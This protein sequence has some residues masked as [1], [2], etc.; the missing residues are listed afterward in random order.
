VNRVRIIPT[1][2]LDDIGLYKTIN[3][4]NPTYIGDPINTVQI[5]NTKEVDELIIID[6][7]ARQN[8]RDINYNYIEE[9]VSEAF[10]PICYGGNINNINQC[11]KLFKL[12]V[13]KISLNY[14]AIFNPK[15]ITELAE[16]FGSQSI[17]VS[18][19][20]KKNFFGK[21]KIYT[22]RGT[23]SIEIDIVT[24]S[25]Q[26]ENYGAGEI[27]LT[28]IDSEGKS[29][30]FDLETIKIVSDSVKIPVIANG[31]CR[32]INDIFLAISEGNASAVAASSMFVYWGKLKGVLINYPSQDILINELFSKFKK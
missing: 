10:M 30:G 32:N 22:E 7:T 21:K 28:S 8:K 29:K 13:E 14:S 5:F 1:L 25:K 15:L 24:L 6:Y 27:L 18:I 4:K 26:V 19:D 17:V 20:F 9:I 31:G 2:L 12:G 11:E 3:F 16:R 23:K